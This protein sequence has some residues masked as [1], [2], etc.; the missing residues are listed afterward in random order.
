[1]NA[2]K[3]KDIEDL[4]VKFL[5]INEQKKDD[6][7]NMIIKVEDYFKLTYDEL[8]EIFNVSPEGDFNFIEY[9]N[10]IPI[11]TRYYRKIIMDD[12]ERLKSLLPMLNIRKM[13][14]CFEF[15]YKDNWAT[16][17]VEIFLYHIFIWVYFKPEIIHK[18][19]FMELCENTLLEDHIENIANEMYRN[20][21]EEINILIDL[22]KVSSYNLK[23]DIFKDMDI[24]YLRLFP[25]HIR[26]VNRTGKRYLYSDK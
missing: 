13:F 5:V 11:D 1:M 25:A 23:F 2:L 12:M 17:F 20:I 22:Y 15:V 16:K 26:M 14:K 7:E 10:S 18:K 19:W 8:N 24:N 6:F 21:K 9:Q 3:M 4:W